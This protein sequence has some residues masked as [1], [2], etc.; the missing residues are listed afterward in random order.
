MCCQSQLQSINQKI[1]M[2][3]MST[4]PDLVVRD[5][6][7]APDG[8]VQSHTVGRT[9]EFVV[10]Y[11]EAMVTDMVANGNIANW[12]EGSFLP[13]NYD[14]T[15]KK[16]TKTETKKQKFLQSKTK[17]RNKILGYY[18]LILLSVAGYCF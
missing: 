8:F 7:A 2:Q 17:A 6:L 13:L 14:T 16:G 5:L 3:N 1:T 4:G 18:H 12:E 15:F 9:G 10:L 11:K